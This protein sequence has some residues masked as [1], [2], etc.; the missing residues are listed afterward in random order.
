MPTGITLTDTLGIIPIIWL[1]A[2]ASTYIGGEV[3]TPTK[4][5]LRATVG[6]MLLYAGIAFVLFFAHLGP[7]D[8]RVQPGARPG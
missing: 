1:I 5:Q 6:G 7:R 2:W 4:T 8:D 3:R